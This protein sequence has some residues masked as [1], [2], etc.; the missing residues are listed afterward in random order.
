MKKNSSEWARLFEDCFYISDREGWGKNTHYSWFEESI[1]LN[2]FVIRVMAST[3]L[4]KKD[5]ND[6][7]NYIQQIKERHEC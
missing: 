2:E 6:I 1:S 3:C 7:N 4:Y 5:W